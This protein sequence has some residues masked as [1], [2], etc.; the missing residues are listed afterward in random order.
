MQIWTKNFYLPK[1]LFS[2]LLSNNRKIIKIGDFGTAREELCSKSITKRRGT[3][4]YMAPEVFD[5]T[6]YTSK[7]DVYS[8]GVTLCEMYTRQRPYAGEAKEGLMEKIQNGLRPTIGIHI[9]ADIQSM[10]KR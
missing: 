5:N 8:F 3:L 7:C 1:Y 2:I 6:H 9:D 10:I 4:S